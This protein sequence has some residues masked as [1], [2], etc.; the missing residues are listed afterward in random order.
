MPSA[1]KTASSKT[2]SSLGDLNADDKHFGELG[3]IPNLGHVIRPRHQSPAAPTSST[4]SSSTARTQWNSP[5]RRRL[6][7]H[8]GIN[9]SLER[10]PCS[11]DHLPIWAEFSVFEGWPSAGSSR[12]GERGR[13][14]VAGLACDIASPSAGSE[15]GVCD[16]FSPDKTL[17]MTVSLPATPTRSVRIGPATI[18]Q[19]HPIA[20]QSMTARIRR[21]LTPRWSR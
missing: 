5:P 15:N 14:A 4:T 18:G 9:L 12:R 19:G 8:A 20:V 1:I 21:I 7:F 2:T 11:L 16:P 10:R 6:R 13:Q 3:R 17:L